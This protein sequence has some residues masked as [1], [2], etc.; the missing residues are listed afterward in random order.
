MTSDLTEKALAEMDK[1][2][3][4]ARRRYYALEDAR[5]QIRND[6]AHVD[7]VGRPTVSRSHSDRDRG[8]CWACHKGVTISKE[9]RA[10]GPWT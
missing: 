1:R 7:G 6:C 2:I 4:R 10:I 9:G 5:E 3:A 8:W